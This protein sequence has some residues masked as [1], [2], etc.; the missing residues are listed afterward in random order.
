MFF[1]PRLEKIRIEFIASP[2][3]L[4]VFN[5]EMSLRSASC[6]GCGREK[7]S[8]NDNSIVLINIS[9]QLLHIL[10]KTQTF[11]IENIYLT[12]CEN[13]SYFSSVFKKS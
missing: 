10:K 4:Y 5:C 9:Y 12:F 7:T 2:T 1:A 6:T 8:Q 13:K 11:F 3:A